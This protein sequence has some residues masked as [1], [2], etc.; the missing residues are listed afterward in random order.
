MFA[1]LD[2]EMDVE[3][4][5]ELGDKTKKEEFKVIFSIPKL[6]ICTEKSSINQ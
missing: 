1:L 3:L 4:D 2:V 5:V 6:F